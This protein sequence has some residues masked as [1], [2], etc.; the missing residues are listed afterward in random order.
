MEDWEVRAREEI[1][2]TLARYNL[3]GDRGDLEGLASCFTEDGILE[4]SGSF[5]ARGRQEIVRCLR[6]PVASLRGRRADALLRH[7]LTTHGVDFE[8]AARARCWTYFTAFTEIGPDHM[9][10]YV[11][12]VQRMGEGWLLS[13]RRVVVEW[14]SP[15][16]R[17]SASSG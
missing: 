13:H 3:C 16:S 9:G 15:Q 11:D 12:Q 17:Y 2:S 6:A 8:G 10:R 14:W 4:V 7:H 1:R 5:A